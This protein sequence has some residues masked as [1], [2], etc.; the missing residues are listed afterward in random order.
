MEIFFALKGGGTTIA[1]PQPGVR[2]GSAQVE[3]ATGSVRTYNELIT[4]IE[5]YQVS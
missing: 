2:F 1:L 5:G 3:T 4:F